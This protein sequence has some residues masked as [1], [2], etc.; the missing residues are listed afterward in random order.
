MANRPERKSNNSDHRANLTI[1]RRTLGLMVLFG[2]VAFVPLMWKLYQLQIVQHEDL[3]GKALRQQTY[4]TSV[5][6]ARG[7]IYDCNGEPLA[8]SAEVH[9]IMIAPR[10]IIEYRKNYS[11]PESN[12]YKLARK[13]PENLWPDPT[14]EYIA[15][16][17]AALLDLEAEKIMERLAKTSSA[18]EVIKYRVEREESSAVE[19]FIAESHISGIYVMP[20]TRRY[21]P[22]ASLA[23]QVIGWVNYNN[24]GKG[25][26]G[27]EAVY[28]EA[29]AGKTGRV[30][31]AKDG[32]GKQ[33]L[34]S[35][36]DYYDAMDGNNVHLTLNKT[37]QHYCEQIL[38]K[39]VEM[40]EVQDGAFAIAMDP[41]TGKILAWA[42]SPTYDLNDPWGVIDPVL[43]TYLETVRSDPGATEE[44]YKAALGEMQNLQWRNKA[45]NE[46]YE[47]GSTFKAMVLA[48]ALEEGV[49]NDNTQ[50][51]C[52][53]YKYVEGY[54][55]PIK[56]SKRAE[57]GGHGAQD[58]AAAVANSCNPAFIEIGQALGAQKFYDYL[59]DFGMIGKTGVDMQGEAD[60]SKGGLV[61]PRSSFTNVDLAVASFG[62]R[63][64]VTPLQIITAA[65]AVVNGGHLM[66]PYM[67]E[68]ITDSSGNTISHTE[69]TEVRQVI[70]ETTSEH[71]RLILEGVVD[72][73][74]GKNA[75]VEG[76][77]VGGKTGSSQTGE[78]DH[79]IVSFLGFAPA[80][81]P[82]VV[83]LLA[84]DNPKPAA[85]GSNLTSKDWYIS[86][87]NMAAL[88]A[89][90]LMGN[91][92]DYLDVEKS[93]T[94]QEDVSV[95]KTSGLTLAAATSRLGGVNL[96]YRT[97]GDG[98][99]VTGQIP[100][101][102][103]M[104][105][106][107][108]QV[109]LYMGAEKPTAKVTV[110]QLTGRSVASVRSALED[111]GLYLRA[112]GAGSDDAVAYSQSIPQGTEVAPGTVIDVEFSQE[113]IDAAVDLR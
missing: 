25:A 104:V 84:Y 66:Q 7:T 112:T 49:V 91:I 43:S 18:Y 32:S 51:F 26:Y 109:L 102:G 23:S 62:Q 57:Q 48:A 9:N 88:M 99:T 107:G 40:F 58:L 28:E 61:W 111:L 70:S 60:N 34:Y 45:I 72:G 106:G 105:P 81:D 42:N 14:D 80:D 67:V 46:T 89:R 13:D 83:I 103:A 55:D 38:E 74:T 36:Q 76:Y 24:D 98:D 59:E 21:Y 64:K 11:D 3:Q 65:S 8:M 20:T 63:F 16:Q 37:I 79:T 56:C 68:K 50:F 52:P 113:S 17:L 73:G 82:Q 54:K 2:V 41:K 69:P 100:E 19:R 75:K 29:L 92:L 22:N 85:P 94:A 78:K 86:G 71:C 12:T 93:Y 110:P 35:F 77:R 15:Q 30:V 53:G 108:S 44:A 31:T 4:D 39:G 101:A 5:T 1:L 6:A 33:M 96:T 90:E 47:P 27:V 87:G 95:P 97:V 10:E